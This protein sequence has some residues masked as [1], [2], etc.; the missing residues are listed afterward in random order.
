MNH[1]LNNLFKRNNVPAS[2]KLDIDNK[3]DHELKA[4]V[5]TIQPAKPFES[6]LEARILEISARK[7]A[8]HNGQGQLHRAAWYQLNTPV[9][10]FSLVGLI[11]VFIITISLLVSPSLRVMAEDIFNFW[12]KVDNERVVTP[13]PEITPMDP[14]EFPAIVDA[15][16]QE[17]KR[18]QQA[19]AVNSED[20]EYII[21]LP[22]L[23]PEGHRVVIVDRGPFGNA[24]LDLSRGRSGLLITVTIKPAYEVQGKILGPDDKIEKV[25][26]DGI[27][28]EYVRGGWG[29]GN[30][31]SSLMDPDAV[32]DLSWIDDYDGIHKLRWID[33]NMS[34]YMLVGGNSLP[35]HEWYLG[36]NDLVKI[37]SSFQPLEN[38]A[39]PPLDFFEPDHGIDEKPFENIKEISVLEDLVRYNLPE[40]SV[41]PLNFNFDNGQPAFTGNSA[42]LNYSCQPKTGEYDFP[43]GNEISLITSKISES[44][45]NW[46]LETFGANEIGEDAVVENISLNGLN[47]Y[48]LKGFR[49]NSQ[50]QSD[51]NSSGQEQVWDN[52]INM[53]VIKWYAD[54]ILYTMQSTTN[55]EEYGSCAITKSNLMKFI[56]DIQKDLIENTYQPPI[57]SSSQEDTNSTLPTPLAEE[58]YIVKLPTLLPEGHRIIV[59]DRGPQ[60]NAILDLS[61]GLSGVL[62]TV[63]IRPASEVQGKIIGPEDKVE[64]VTINDITY[65]YVRGGWGIG[66]ALLTLFRTCHGLMI[67]MGSINCAGLTA[68]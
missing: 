34:Y 53:F 17:M 12:K 39:R 19:T 1:K 49:V 35:G 59:V 16:Q 25:T 3:F 65:E 4:V 20:E 29:I 51:G 54:G 66:N 64:R 56:T 13:F 6:Q 48:Y 50:N 63:T 24:F 28:Y 26:I 61:R 23:L 31:F 52:Q 32:Q 46:E 30:S 9:K 36:M 8:G 43:N 21:K 44:Q 37:A 5:G 22:T 41:F 11:V 27:T 38:G 7:Q 42:I 57:K 45:I 40:A 15:I 14:D 2:E 47:V 33:G 68:I 18:T 58:E 60:G 62:M 55:Y 67:M 10:K